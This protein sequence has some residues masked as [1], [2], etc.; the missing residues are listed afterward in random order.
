MRLLLVVQQVFEVGVLFADLLAP[1]KG[2][3]MFVKLL[4]SRNA[5]FPIEVTPL[6]IITLVKLLQQ[7]NAEEPIEATLSGISMFVKLLHPENACGLI[8][9]TVLGIVSSVTNSSF[10]Y[11]LFA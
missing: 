8:F 4:Q 3:L 6:G 5:P 10:K 9:V 2:K 11:K 1:T 7:A